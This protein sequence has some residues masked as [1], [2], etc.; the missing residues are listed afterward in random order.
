MWELGEERPDFVLRNMVGASID[1]IV[2]KVERTA[3]RAQASR[4]QAS[5]S[6]R[7]FF[8]AREDLHTAGSRITCRMLA[9]GPRRCLVDCYG[10]DLDMTQRDPL[11][12]HPG[13]SHGVPPGLGDRLHCK[14]VSP[15]YR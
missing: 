5:R 12:G 7:R 15:P 1:V 13:T 14:G 2:T 10:Y 9:V 8:A 11:R 6:Q 3:N 4:R